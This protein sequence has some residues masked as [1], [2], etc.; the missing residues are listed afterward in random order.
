MTPT[1]STAPNNATVSDEGEQPDPLIHISSKDRRP[2]SDSSIQLPSLRSW[3]LS[4]PNEQPDQ[5]QG[6]PSESPLEKSS[7]RS[8][9]S[10]VDSHPSASGSGRVTQP[11]SH[12]QQTQAFHPSSGSRVPPENQCDDQND[13]APTKPPAKKGTHWSFDEDRIIIERQKSGMSWKEI[14]QHLPGRGPVS[15]YNHFSDR[16][17]KPLEAEERNPD[18]PLEQDI[19]LFRNIGGG[20]ETW[21]QITNA[22][23]REFHTSRIPPIVMRHYENEKAKTTTL[24]SLLNKATT[25][26]LLGNSI[27]KLTDWP[28]EQDIFLFEHMGRLGWVETV[29]AFNRKFR[30]DRTAQTI[31]MHYVEETSKEVTLQSLQEKALSC[32]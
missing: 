16:L 2:P 24:Q 9:K 21:P 19:F 13:A 17:K 1:N 10:L 15:C 4:R 32:D 11:L 25:E 8:S 31:S 6:L 29:K 28:V 3:A 23:N 27:P 26:C 12:A 5:A 30:T 7:W 18:W 20:L 14:S 22:L